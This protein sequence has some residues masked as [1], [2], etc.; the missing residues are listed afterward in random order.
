MALGE[1]SE[2]TAA[3]TEDL[4]VVDIGAY[5]VAEYGAVYVLGADRPA[6]VD[7]G[8]GTEYGVI[9]DALRSVGIA[10]ADLEAILLTHVHLDHAGGAGYLAEACPNAEVYVHERGAPHVADP[11]RLWAGTKRAVP[12]QIDFYAEP[13]PVAPERIVE[14]TDGDRID[15]GDRALRVRHAPGHAPHQVVLYDPTN[16][17]VFTGDA[18]GIYA[19]GTGEIRPTSPPS[20]FDLEGCLADIGTIRGLE[21]A[22]LYYGHFGDAETGDRLDAFADALRA[23]VDRIAA[24]RADLGDDE[25]VIDH[26]G[27]TAST[28]D[29]WGERRSRAEA[30]IN[31]RG[32]LG[33]LDRRDDGG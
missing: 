33:Y 5:G 7:T 25:A 31:A 1:V 30:R 8:L 18:A 28:F 21:S 3:G 29:Y 24:A 20:N 26:V 15:L 19:R 2:A 23:W 32:V 11:T 16:D 12:E 22:A 6:V 10:P 13:E 14:L 4:H 17:G 9:L 27:E